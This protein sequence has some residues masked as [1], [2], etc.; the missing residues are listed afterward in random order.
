MQDPL[1]HIDMVMRDLNFTLVNAVSDAASFNSSKIDCSHV[2]SASFHIFFSDV[3]FAGS[4]KIQA[5]ND[6][7]G[8]GNLALDFTPSHW[9][10]IPSK[11][12]TATAGGA[13]LIE[14]DYMK[15]RWVRAVVT[16]T[17]PG[18]GT[19]SINVDGKAL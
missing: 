17:T 12:V 15:F 3:A 7:C 10:D 14:I 6:P 2:V 18:S 8:Y 11:S 1:R 9:V 5:S 13:F 16:Q 4:V 19:V